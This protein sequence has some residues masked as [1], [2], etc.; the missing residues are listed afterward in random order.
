MEN[1]THWDGVYS[2]K[3]EAELSWH[4]DDPSVS[5][6]LMHKAGLSA[7]TSVI[8]IGGGTS[9]IVDGLLA[10]GLRD[11]SVLDLSENALLAARQRLGPDSD[12]VTWITADVTRWRAQRTYDLW[13]DRAVF[14]F[15]TGPEDRA[16]YLRRLEKSL[17]PAGHAIIAT[18][19]LDGPEKCSGL[20]VVRYSP[21]TLAATLGAG[22]E[23]VVHQHHE[24]R[25]P[26]GSPQAFQYSLFRK[27]S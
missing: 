16:A 10:A 24:H 22:F 3:T 13:H 8:D 17:S 19:S 18:F 26:W 5:F 7:A 9:R 4:Q 6:D 21:D 25:T 1:R 14:H 2:A 20:P 11:V 23:R 27:R 12:K 15:L